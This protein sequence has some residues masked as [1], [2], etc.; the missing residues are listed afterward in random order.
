MKFFW[1]FHLLVSCG[2]KPLEVKITAAKSSTITLAKTGKLSV[3]LEIRRLGSETNV[4]VPI[5]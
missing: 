1:V 5:S 3:R 4:V 2:V